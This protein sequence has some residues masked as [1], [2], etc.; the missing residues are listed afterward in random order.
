ML[1]PQARTEGVVWAP[2]CPLQ[3]RCSGFPELT[4]FE[5]DFL[6]VDKLEEKMSESRGKKSRPALRG[7]AQ[8]PWAAPAGG[9]WQGLEG[10]PSRTQTRVASGRAGRVTPTAVLAACMTL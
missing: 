5:S 10:P 3:S 8:R 6:V 7:E 9:A 1:V 2:P 4:E